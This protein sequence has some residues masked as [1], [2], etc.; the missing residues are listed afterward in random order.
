MVP[1]QTSKKISSKTTS[2]VSIRSTTPKIEPSTFVAVTSQEELDLA[3][4]NLSVEPKPVTFPELPKNLLA[5][6]AVLELARLSVKDQRPRVNL[7]VIGN[8][9][10]YL[11]YCS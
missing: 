11:A 3:S 5:R 6:D 9:I 1:P 2:N 7:V 4:L 10:Y 8:W